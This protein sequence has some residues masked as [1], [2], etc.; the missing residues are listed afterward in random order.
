MRK[1]YRSD[2]LDEEW[3]L[4]AHLVE[5]PTYGFKPKYPRREILNAIFYIV[6]TGCQWRNL[7]HDLPPWQ[8]VYTT[9]RNWQ[10]KGLFEK[11]NEELR[12]RLRLKEGRKKEASGAVIDSQ[13]AKTTE[14]GGS[15]LDTTEQRRSKEEKDI[16]LS[17]PKGFYYKLKSLQVIL[18]INKGR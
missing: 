18:A 9:F 10:L 1:P 3:A 4:I 11:I 5:G 7:P 17:I 12:N 8:T 15:A 16:F 2:L 13:T 6:R 14:K